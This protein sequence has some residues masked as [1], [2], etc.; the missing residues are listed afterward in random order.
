MIDSGVDR[1]E[2]AQEIADSL[3]IG[4]HARLSRQGMRGWLGLGLIHLAVALPR[5]RK[6]Q[7]PADVLLVVANP[8]AHGARLA[9]AI[10]ASLSGVRVSVVADCR[11]ADPSL[12]VGLTFPSLA[13]RSAPQIVTARRLHRA[14]SLRRLLDQWP[15][16]LRDLASTY[17]LYVYLVQA[18][19][20]DAAMD[21][22]ARSNAA[23]G[24]VTDFDRDAY[25]RP[26]S[27]SS[28]ERG[29]P[30]VTLVHGTPT[31]SNYL[32]LL[33][34]D[35]LVWGPT[36]SVWFLS[37][38]DG[39]TTHIVG[40][41]E[42]DRRIPWAG[43]VRRA[44]VCH[45]AEDLSDDEMARVSLFLDA[46]SR[47]AVHSIVRLHPSSDGIH[48]GRGWSTVTGRADEVVQTRT[49]LVTSLDDGDLVMVVTSSAAVDAVAVGVPAVVLA[50]AQRDLPCDLELLRDLS[51]P[52]LQQINDR[53][54]AVA[55]AVR[56]LLA[57]AGQH[58]VPYTGSEAR[59][60]VLDVWRHMSSRRIK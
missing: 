24:V 12:N 37:R 8:V 39:V 9:K 45:S 32:P 31:S 52:L 23:F 47:L 30:L 4:D 42:I 26:W 17:R 33:A 49:P 22:I 2:L 57:E 21:E 19:R 27:W 41:P 35:V 10:Q 25:A 53:D 59:A 36:Q 55:D 51:D 43:P 44:I 28:V 1:Y 56:I 50:D 14:W 5:K 6:V 60:R 46:M 29:V 11:L 15:A 34:Q 16:H 13:V 3:R 7:V 48:L 40:R 54:D 18:M 20:Y 58:L 38:A